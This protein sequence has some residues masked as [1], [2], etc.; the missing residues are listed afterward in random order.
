MGQPTIP[1]RPTPRWSPH[2]CRN[3]WAPHATARTAAAAGFLLR[4]KG[5]GPDEGL[6]WRWRPAGAETRPVGSYCG[7]WVPIVEQGARESRASVAAVASFRSVYCRSRSTLQLLPQQAAAPLLLTLSLLPPLLSRFPRW[8]RSRPT[9]CA[10]PSTPPPRTT[11]PA[12]PRT[13][14][15]E[16]PPHTPL[17]AQPRNVPPARSPSVH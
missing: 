1:I 5:T 6:V 10:G 13:S 7:L 17:C 12:A 11:S 15:D 3:L 16:P 8:C 4:S 9:C 14:R 2:C